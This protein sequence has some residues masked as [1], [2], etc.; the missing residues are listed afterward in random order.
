MNARAIIEG[1]TPKQLMRRCAL[2]KFYLPKWAAAHGYTPQYGV[3]VEDTP[4]TTRYWISAKRRSAAICVVITQLND[5]ML[6]VETEATGSHEDARPGDDLVL[7]AYSSLMDCTNAFIISM[8]LSKMADYLSGQAAVFSRRRNAVYAD[9][10]MPIAESAVS[11]LEDTGTC[12][13]R[14][15][16]EE[17]RV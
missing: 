9:E 4:Y 5:G 7:Q 16:M 10:L 15:K 11:I 8:A 17:Y 14:A 12:I 13:E 1:E 3:G 2:R 6:R